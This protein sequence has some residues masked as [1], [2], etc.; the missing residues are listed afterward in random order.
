M[1][2]PPDPVFL[3]RKAYRRRRMADG[4]KLL[5]V[6]GVLLFCLPLLW[7]GGENGLST[8]FAM[9][10]LF[11]VWAVMALIAAQVSRF[12]RAPPR[13]AEDEGD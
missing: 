10:Y 13:D 8:T 7:G 4:A 9:L 3:D 2:R 11:G 1:A 6:F 12:L 5:P